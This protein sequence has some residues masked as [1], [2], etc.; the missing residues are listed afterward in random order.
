MKKDWKWIGQGEDTEV[1]NKKKGQK[2]ML[3]QYYSHPN[4]QFVVHI[5][6]NKPTSQTFKIIGKKDGYKNVYDASVFME[7][8]IKKH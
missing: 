3:Y 4:R 2:L 8:Y 7:E 1:I 6:S 5:D